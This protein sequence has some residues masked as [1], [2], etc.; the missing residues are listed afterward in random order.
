M[1]AG[2]GRRMRAWTMLQ[3][4][5]RLLVAALVVAGTMVAADT[6]DAASVSLS[7]DA[8][9]TNANGTPL[10]DLAG[11]RVY[12]ATS[13]PA[14]P[15]VSFHPVAS[16]TTAPAPGQTVSSRITSLNA[17]TTYFVRITAVDTTG[18][19]SACSSSA[20]GIAKADFSVT[21]SAT[22]SFGSITL[23]GV[24]DRTF[25]VQ[26]TSSTTI[27]G[28][29]S[30][31]APYSVVSGAS[32][33][34]S[35][36]ASQDVTVRFRP[37]VAGTFAG[38][39]N[40]TVSGDT[41]SRA[42]NGSVTAVPTFA[43]SV[44]KNGTGGGTVTST[45]AGIACGAD[46]SEAI[47]QGTPVTLTAAAVS[48]STFAGWGGACSGTTACAVTVNTA[49]T[50]TA[51]FNTSPPL[52][53]TPV[54]VA[55]SL[56]PVS[57]TAG[58][59][60]LMLTVNGRGFVPTSV[61]R[62]KGGNR[63]TTFVS[64][65]QLRAAITVADLAVSGSIPVTVYTPAP[66]G[67]TSASKSFSVTAT[68]A[69][70]APP[71][72]STPP[73]TPASPRVTQSAG[74]ATGV[75]YTIGWGAASG[76]ASYRYVAGFSDGTAGQQG[77]VTG[78]LSLQLRMP[79]HASG[80]AF[81]GFVCLRAVSAAGLQS[82]D[83]ACSGLSVPARPSTSP[84][85]P[86]PMASGLSPASAVAGSTAMPL[87]VNGSGFGAASVVRWNGS[88]RAT[89]VVSA[90][91]LSITLTAADLAT[92]RSVPVTVFT[93]APGGGISAAV[94]F[95]VT[96]PPAPGPAPS[97]PPA[98]PP[99]PGARLLA[100]DGGGVTFAVSWGPVSGATSYRYLAAFSDGSAQRQGTATGSSIDLW[101][102][103]HASGMS[104]GA[105]VCVRSV[106]AAGV[107][108]T[109]QSCGPIAVPARGR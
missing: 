47:V 76:A 9:T 52:Q 105:F 32:F 56:S 86:V 46:C 90:T 30:I 10:T 65:S 14:C 3:S 7:W 2:L 89:T 22:T 101:M 19:E 75:T 40:F 12:M 98:A 109:S 92:A 31:G 20:S 72:P 41:L 102:P 27:S 21:P 36:G 57:A 29:A 39:V 82:L 81:N 62:W 1:I 6:V 59:A 83:Q 108:S 69:A 4:R 45:P 15:G 51:T 87:T 49:T 8:P 24:V 54:P 50:V 34:L 17:G 63:T 11:Y 67:G 91:Q 99:S 61:V 93:P 25:T 37:T 104:F 23:G 53:P 55:S 35:P 107:Q 95:V 64:A 48:G 18:N 84:T 73:A 103:Y 16:S 94:S 74:D 77:T 13:Q 33:S 44:T 97:T 66:G 71:A 100:S 60:G 28:T 78:L 79:Y 106:N 38:N 85:S 70:P 43:L 26:N 88:A 42:V 68:P 80:A 58:T 96:A 5:S